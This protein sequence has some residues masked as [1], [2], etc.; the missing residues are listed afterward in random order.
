MFLLR[1]EGPFL[2]KREQREVMATFFVAHFFSSV[3][4]HSYTSQMKDPRKTGMVMFSIVHLRLSS[5]CCV[6]KQ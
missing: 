1:I 2:I 6:S 4:W 3:T 5:V